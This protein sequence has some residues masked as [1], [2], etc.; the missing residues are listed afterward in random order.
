MYVLF[1]DPR[2]FSACQVVK[3]VTRSVVASNAAIAIRM[4]VCM[5]VCRCTMVGSDMYM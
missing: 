3:I 5:Y 2:Q 1:S 4:Y